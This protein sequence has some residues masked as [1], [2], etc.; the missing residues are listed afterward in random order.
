MD[1][2][3]KLEP[4]CEH[5]DSRNSYECPSSCKI[6]TSRKERPYLGF[7]L[8]SVPEQDAYDTLIQELCRRMQE[9]PDEEV[10]VGS[11]PRKRSEATSELLNLIRQVYLGEYN[12]HN[13]LREWFLR[14][15]FNAEKEAVT[16]LFNR[17][18]E[19]CKEA[20]SSAVGTPEQWTPENCWNLMNTT[21]EKSSIYS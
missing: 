7:Y 19:L 17:A 18:T 4:V 15:P 16:E 14:D 3:T 9:K 21:C 11:T 5:V 13:E 1:E 20:Y 8:F 6:W 2:N 12:L 10:M